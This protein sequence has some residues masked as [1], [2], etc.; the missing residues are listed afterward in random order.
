[1]DVGTRGNRNVIGAARDRLIGLARG[2]APERALL[3]FWACLPV[4]LYCQLVLAVGL[5][6][7]EALATEFS[8]PVLQLSVVVSGAVTLYWI[9]LGAWARHLARRERPGRQGR[10]VLH[11]ALGSGTLSAN[12][13]VY[14]AGSLT[15]PLVLAIATIGMLAIHLLGRRAAF[16]HLALL[17]GAFFLV[18]GLS[19]ADA[20]PYAPLVTSPPGSLTG[21]GAF[22]IFSHGAIGVLDLLILWSLLSLVEGENREQQAR[23]LAISRTDAL[24][25]VANRR[26]FME[27]LQAEVGRAQREHTVLSLLILDIDH[28]KQINDS[29]GH[30]VGDTVIQAVAQ[31]LDTHRRGYDLVARYGGEEFVLMLPN[32]TTEQAVVI[33]ERYRGLI[34]SLGGDPSIE[35]VVR[36]SVSGGV[37]S[38]SG[39]AVASAEQ[40]LGIADEALYAAK[41]NGRNRVE[42]RSCA[43]I[44]SAQRLTAGQPTAAWW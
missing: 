12:I 3:V 21:I 11:L 23:L 41:R 33:A 2:A 25:Q 37:A 1:M 32:T 35:P 5:A 4:A 30:L 22:W 42:Q 17:I 39:D 7:F 13:A 9:L 8:Q 6:H 16:F 43:S 18:L 14:L 38:C 31:C 27:Q 15:S 28:F 19:A 36:L 26:Y 34:E 40:L 29:F 24:T 20:I 10:L 44:C